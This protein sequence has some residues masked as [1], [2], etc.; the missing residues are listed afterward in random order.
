MGRSKGTRSRRQREREEQEGLEQAKSKAPKLVQDDGQPRIEALFREGEVL[1]REQIEARIA[2][3]GLV[4]FPEDE[5]FRLT[6]AR[7]FKRHAGQFT[8]RG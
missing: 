5:F 1:S 4:R 2:Q 7:F 3:S 8:V 6:K